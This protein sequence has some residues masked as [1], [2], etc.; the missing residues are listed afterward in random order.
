[1]RLLFC[2]ERSANYPEMLALLKAL[3]KKNHRCSVL[4]STNVKRQ[5]IAALE[6]DALRALHDEGIVDTLST[7]DLA[8]IH[9]QASDRA[10]PIRRF[11][12][13]P[14]PTSPS[15][16]FDPPFIT[17]ATRYPNL[18][19]LSNRFYVYIKPF[20]RLLRRTP[21]TIMNNVRYR[22]RKI[23]GFLRRRH[24]MQR[25]RGCRQI[26]FYY[27]FFLE[28][29]RI[30]FRTNTFDA[31]ILPEEV[32][33]VVWESL[34]KVSHEFGITT[35]VCP[36]TIA[37]QQE[38]FQSLKNRPEFQTRNNWLVAHLYPRWRMQQDG[39]D[40]VR[41]PESHL[42][43]HERLGLVPRDPWL[44]NSGA[45]DAL[46]V[47]NQTIKQYFIDSGIESDRVCVTG[48]TTM[49]EMYEIR[50]QR[51][52][53]LRSVKTIARA[54]RRVPRARHG[55]GATAYSAT[56]ETAMEIAKTPTDAVVR[57]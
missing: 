35:V 23:L 40:L 16:S 31:I 2:I 50:Q 48:S 43:A 24:V 18:V 25:I 42:F 1:M 37:N 53:C 38:A 5:K 19:R 14:I 10:R 45:I 20:R 52:A 28:E 46:C 15:S 44:M 39:Y 34:I 22:L 57:S 9:Q 13:V 6:H 3:A 4:L 8:A 56:L 32:V 17:F 12:K 54:R 33:G 51:H 27:T 47:E 55:L 41:L 26:L 21:T 30:L 11:N 7:I 36:Y 29:L 49:D